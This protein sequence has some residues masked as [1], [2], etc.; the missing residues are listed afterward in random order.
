MFCARKG[1]GAYVVACVRTFLDPDDQSQSGG[2][3]R[4][5]MQAELWYFAGDFGVCVRYQQSN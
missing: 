2:T 5:H 3:L 1:G 4:S